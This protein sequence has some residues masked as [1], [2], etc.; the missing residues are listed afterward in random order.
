MTQPNVSVNPSNRMQIAASAFTPDPGGSGNGPIFLS[1]DGGRTWNLSI[2]L[3]GGNRTVDI[4][5]RFSTLSNVLY[6]GIIRQDDDNL[7]IL[8]KNNILLPGLMTVLESR[9]D[10]DQPYVEAATV[11]GGAGAGNDRVYVGHNDLSQSG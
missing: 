7:N 8:R 11:S 2:V 9:A 10:D 3:P 4:T 5:I 1:N 6:A